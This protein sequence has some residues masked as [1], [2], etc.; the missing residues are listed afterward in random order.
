M[1]SKDKEGSKTFKL[2]QLLSIIHSLAHALRY[3]QAWSLLLLV[4]SHTP[5]STESLSTDCLFPCSQTG[6]P[7]KALLLSL[8]RPMLRGQCS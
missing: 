6:R 2:C 3:L 8:S 5:P 7:V 4:S 1:Q